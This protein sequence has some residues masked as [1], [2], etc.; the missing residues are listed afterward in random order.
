M[1]MD[2]FEQLRARMVAE[3]IETRGV[4][5]EPVLRAMR[6]VPREAFIDSAL[7]EFAYDDKPLPIGAGQTISQP[8]IVALMLD[9]AEMEPGARVLE[10][11][12][13]SGYATAVISRI[14]GEVFA[15]ERHA[16]L[17]EG[18]QKKLATLGYDNASVR[19]ADG[20]LGW[21]EHA[22][23]AAIIVSAGGPSAP[24]A[25]LDQLAI[26][27]RLV[28]PIGD[29]PRAQRLLRI[30]R[31]AEDRYDEDDLGPVLFVPLIGAAG[32]GKDAEARSNPRSL[33]AGALTRLIRDSVEPIDDIESTPLS[34]LLERIGGARVVLLGEATHGTA[35]F[36]RMRARVTRELIL[37]QGFRAVAVEAD[38]PD[39][40]VVD[41][42]VRH[43]PAGERSSAPFTRFPTWMWQNQETLELVEWLREYNRDKPDPQTRVSFHGL[44]LYTLDASAAEVIRYLERVDPVAA[45]AAR[46]RYG[47]LTPWE[48]DPAAYGRAA[49]IG[50]YRDCEDGVVQTLQA[51]LAKRLQYAASDGDEFLNAVQ[52]ARLVAGA[53]RYYRV[54]YYGSRASWN[55]RDR[56]M[57]ETLEALLD[58]RGGDS[59]IVVWAHNSHL[60]DARATEMAAR[61]ELNVGSLCR[62]RFGDQ[63][64]AV[65][66]GTNVGTVAAASAWDE[67]MEVMSL[68][69]ARPESYERLFHDAGVPACLLPLRHPRRDAARTELCEPRLERAVGVVYRPDTELQSHYFQAILP[70]QFDEYVWFDR[71][72]AITPLPAR[73]QA[74]MPDTFPFGL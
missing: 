56:H 3:H 66:F 42:Y 34:A 5:S 30:T 11:G 51:L 74:G 2:D 44:D 19:H 32:W 54:M 9:S 61:G 47:C 36:Y 70:R 64:F 62:E 65:G 35:E 57:F 17:A 33:G 7:A 59:K 16:G 26:G 14:A 12:A 25:L 13:G 4:T 28:M 48:G 71:T 43:L 67:P 69:P 21:P 45:R 55:L 22:P 72:T 20:T 41:R 29:T 10:I 1:T 31:R 6:S 53:E 15:V 27:G 52:N 8:Y 23:Y 63:V 24:P 68:R 60:G 73:P 58:F 50:Q 39:A 38:W 18:A 49:L 46:E 40:A 37:R